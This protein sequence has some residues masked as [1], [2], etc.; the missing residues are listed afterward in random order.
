[1]FSKY[2]SFKITGST[3]KCLGNKV[4]I[5]R[6]NTTYRYITIVFYFTLQHISAVEI[7]HHQAGVGYIKRNIWGERL[8]FTLS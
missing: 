5:I 2:I 7:S 3:C 8:L 1:M 6:P 4:L